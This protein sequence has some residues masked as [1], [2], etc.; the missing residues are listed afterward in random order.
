MTTMLGNFGHIQY[1]T[2][3]NAVLVYREDNTHGCEDFTKFFEANQMVL[4]QAGSCPVT[5]KVRNIE[6]AGG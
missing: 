4:V 1:G 3:I 6:K 5:T 2:T